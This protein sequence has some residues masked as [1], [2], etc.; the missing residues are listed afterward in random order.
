MDYFRVRRYPD[1]TYHFQRFRWLEAKSIRFSHLSL[2]MSVYNCRGARKGTSNPFD[3]QEFNQML[4]KRLMFGLGTVALAIASAAGSNR[5]DLSQPTFVGNT[6]L[7]PG[8]YKVAIQGGTAVFTNGKTV[9]EAPVTVEKSDHAVS[10][11]EV[12]TKGSK[13][14]EIRLGGT[15][16]RLIFKDATTSGTS[17][18]Q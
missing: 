2:R 7:K 5:I 3:I 18:G 10:L 8:S 12:E 4:L 13:I 15:T 14:T 11:T 9:V 6:Q 1:G 16:T 17:A